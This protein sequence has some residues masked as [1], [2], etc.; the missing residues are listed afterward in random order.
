M[1]AFQWTDIRRPPPKIKIAPRLPGVA[2]ARGATTDT[3][4]QQ[5]HAAM[6]SERWKS[7]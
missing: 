5:T 4:A 3:A 1:D 7:F 6:I 2:V